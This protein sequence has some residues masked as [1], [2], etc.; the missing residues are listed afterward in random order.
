MRRVIV[1]VTITAIG[2]GAAVNAQTPTVTTQKEAKVSP[3]TCNCASANSPTHNQRQIAIDAR[4]GRLT[5][6]RDVPR[7][8]TVAIVMFNK[9]PFLYR[10]EQQITETVVQESA[11][12]VF[13]TQLSPFIAGVVPTPSGVK[14]AAV[15]DLRVADITCDAAAKARPLLEEIADRLQQLTTKLTDMRAEIQTIETA[16]E[17]LRK[18]YNTAFPILTNSL[19]TCQQLCDEATRLRAALAPYDPKSTLETATTNLLAAESDSKSVSTVIDEF[20]KAFPD[21]QPRA[22]GRNVLLDNKAYAESIAIGAIN[23]LRAKLNLIQSDLVKFQTA[24]ES[25][26]RALGNAESFSQVR[27]V[28]P[29]SVP[30]T[31]S[32]AVSRYAATDTDGKTKMPLASHEVHFGGGARFAI[33]GGIV[34]VGVLPTAEFQQVRGIELDRHGVQQNPDTLTTIVG[35]KH[36][37]K[38]R[39]LPMLLLHARALP[40]QRWL[41]A[42]FG[43][44]GRKD[45]ES[46][47]VEYLIGPSVSFLDH[48]VF[49]TPGFYYGKRQFLAG[50]LYR[51]AKIPETLTAIPIQKRFEPAFAATITFRIR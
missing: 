39:V 42:T 9:N 36:D 1:T 38:R 45:N 26:D 2:Y 49:V 48:R 20:R 10:Y 18:A 15:G 31:V 21:C 32:V 40:N 34:Y 25:V 19:S 14:G 22:N 44:T 46:T 12:A 28:G 33:S 11:L 4:T 35:L 51:G 41:H 13:L 47:D 24:K 29:F 6:P 7:E 30:T 5:G 8:S 17:T 43:I 37:S 27:L 50:D 16:H 3:D 23:N